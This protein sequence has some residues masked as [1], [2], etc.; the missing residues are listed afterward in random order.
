[1][2]D[3]IR[4]FNKND[5]SSLRYRW[6]DLNGNKDLDYPNEVGAFIGTD[7]ITSTGGTVFN[8]DLQQPYT[9]EFTTHVERQ[10]GGGVALRAGYVYKKE[11]NLFQIVNTARPFS[12]YNVPIRTVDPGPDGVVGSLDDGGAVT[13]FDYDPAY[14]GANFE[15]ATYINTPGYTDRFHNIEF[16][17]DKRMSNNWQFIAT[18][19]ATR[20]NMWLGGVPQ[21]PNDFFP[22]NETWETTYRVSG[23]YT[24]PWGIVASGILESQ[25]GTPLARDVL[26]R[27]GLT[28]LASLTVR[29]EP[30][31]TQRLPAVR[32]LN[33][34]ATKQFHLNRNRFSVQF[35]LYNALNSSDAT[36]ESFRS[37]PTYGTI[38]AILP[39]RVARLGINY[40][41]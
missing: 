32:L 39:P 22:K 19:L 1:L 36:S 31:G 4:A 8:P 38:S 20:K 17:M 16:G 7:G 13:Y 5:Y 41:F 3:V 14:R 6:N 18:Y 9:D 27:T 28:S 11:A 30:I 10:V 15:K 40:S 29:M 23:S 35:D 34:R 12:V 21:T 26:Y 37:G 24:A 33:V 25:S 2:S